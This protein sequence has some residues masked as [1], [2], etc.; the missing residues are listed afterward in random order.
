MASTSTKSIQPASGI[1]S[2]TAGRVIEFI[3]TTTDVLGVP[4]VKRSD[5]S[6][7]RTT[8]LEPTTTPPDVTAGTGGS[9]GTSANA[10]HADH[11]HG[12]PFSTLNTVLGAASA[13]LSIN[14]QKL[15]SLAN[16]VA[17]TDAATVGQLSAAIQGRQLKDPVACATTANITL[18]G[19]QTIDGFS[20]SSSR[21]LVKNQTTT[22]NNGIYVSASGAWT[23][24]V[25]FD[26]A[27]EA[28]NASTV[29]SNGA[30]S[31]G[32]TYTSNAI[33]TLGTDPITWTQTGEG[34]A[35]TLAAVG[36]T[37]NANGA[38]I[39]NQV[40][41][42]QP[43]STSFPGL[44]TAAQ[45]TTLAAAVTSFAVTSPI[46]NTGTATAPNV[47]LTAN[48][49]TNAFLATGAASTVKGS[50]TGTG[51]TVDLTATQLT[52]LVQ[53][54][55]AVLPGALSSTLF[56]FTQNLS[57]GFFNVVSS[58]AKGDGTTDDTAAI[59]AAIGLA[60]AYV[61]PSTTQRGAT[62]YFPPGIYKITGAL[63][64]ISANGIQLLGAGRGATTILVDAATGDTITLGT[65]TEFCQIRSMQ[66]F[67]GVARTAGSFVNVNGAN[68][69]IIDDFTMSGHF[70]GITVQNAAIKVYITRGTIDSAASTSSVGIL[71]SN[72]AAGDTYIGDIVMS[73]GGTIPLAG[74]RVQQT[75]HCRIFGCNVTKCDTGLLID[76]G[77]SQDVTYMFVDDSLFDSGVSNGIKI[78]P[79][80]I[81][82]ARV[83]SLK[84]TDCWG[85]GSSAG[86]GINLTSQ[87]A[88]AVVDDVEFVATRVLNNSSHGVSHA[89]GT[90]IRFIGGSIAGNSTASANAADG[91]NISAGVTDWSYEGVRI[92]PVGTAT[93]TQRWAINIGAGASTN[94][95]LLNNDLRGN[96]S[97]GTASGALLD[98]STASATKVKYIQGNLGLAPDSRAL[99]AVSATITTTEVV[100]HQTPNV[101]FGALNVETTYC[102]EAWGSISATGTVTVKAK[103][104]TAGTIADAQISTSAVV[105]GAAGQVYAR[106]MFTVRSIGAAGTIVG[107]QSEQAVAV[108]TGGQSNNAAT[109]AVNTQAGNFI[110]LTAL[111]SAGNLTFNNARIWA[112]QQ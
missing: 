40:L 5:G 76:P 49:V 11:A 65:S 61:T 55:T 92:G 26:T 42:L 64:T 75:G 105:S 24:A 3:D 20:T 78:N 72:G 53:L 111:A 45:A 16:G 34:A 88:S 67:A 8:G 59:N 98:A 86:V 12:L 19:E 91:V 81:A 109:T 89:F 95:K 14:N 35:V 50:L 48:G 94:Y 25:D 97:G 31:Q 73:N 54:A 21:V 15:S 23:R 36:G 87:G 83:R 56:A 38:S 90:N 74:I 39:T 107:N 9:L 1:G 103:I 52:T 63:T 66:F 102:W 13:A 18:T 6:I 43:S 77:T 71:V 79:A 84:F 68:D 112:L 22:A 28:S 69:V 41:T 7:V 108:L 85:A 44:M 110:S 47:A 99:T 37:P 62:V 51:N 100:F 17:A 58:G 60:L 93:N 30:V 101:P 2:I 57:G 4:A 104:G 80:N 27:A 33:T 82:T 32:D 96:G 106:G 29:V 10:A 46:A 70:T